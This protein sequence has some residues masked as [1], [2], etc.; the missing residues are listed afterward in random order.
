MATKK[1]DDSL[2]MLKSEVAHY[3]AK[4][5]NKPQPQT[6]KKPSANYTQAI[7]NE[8]NSARRKRFLEIAK[9]FRR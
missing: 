7:Q 9:K 4:I 6:M 3:Q 5:Q 8:A 2:N 1:L